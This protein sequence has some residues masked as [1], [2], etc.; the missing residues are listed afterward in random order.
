MVSERASSLG[1]RGQA[2]VEAALTLPLTIFLIL[3]SLQLFMMLQGRIM[4]EYAAFEA[5]RAGSRY[6]GDCKPMTHAVLAAL[7]PS[8]VP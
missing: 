3:G 8:V 5:V 6:H 2:A 4:S 7:L 1:E